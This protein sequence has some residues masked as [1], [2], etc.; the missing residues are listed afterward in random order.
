VWLVGFEAAWLIT[1]V[2][3][4]RQGRLIEHP[5]LIGLLVV[6]SLAVWYARR[7]GLSVNLPLAAAASV[8][9]LVWLGTGFHFNEHT[10]VG[11]NVTDEVLNE[12]AKTLWALAYFVPLLRKPRW[13]RTAPA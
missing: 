11:L 8:V 4:G 5:L 2:A 10:T 9:W 13:L 6:G 1:L 12:T 3:L 7:R